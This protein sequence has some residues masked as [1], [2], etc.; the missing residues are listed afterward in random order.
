MKKILLID[1]S[2]LI[3]RAFYAI[4]NL[5]TKDNIPTGAVYGFMNM[6][7][8][9]MEKIKPDYVLVA[10]DKAGPTFRTLE[11]D[12]Y[13]ANR[14]K[15]P[16][17]LLLQFGLV[18]D[19]LDSYNVKH[20]ALD[21]YEADDIIGTVAKMANNENISVF[22]LTGDKDYFQ[23]I[24]ENSKVLFTKK[25]V[26][27]FEEYDQLKINSVYGIK[28]SEL[29]EVK[30]LM[31]DQSDNIPGVPGIGE[32][33]AL[34]LIKEYGNIE[35]IYENLDK[36]SGKSLKEKLMNNKQKA[37]MS[38]KI[39]KIFTDIKLGIDISDLTIKEPNS[40]ELYEKYKKLEFHRFMKLYS[41]QMKIDFD[42]YK[43]NEFKLIGINRIAD[44]C[45]YILNSKKLVFDILNKGDYLNTNPICIAIKGSNDHYFV[46]DLRKD[47]DIFIKKFKN[48]FEDKEILKISFDIKK[49]IILLK[50]INIDLSDNYLDLMI[51]AYLLNPS[52]EYTLKDISLSELDKDIKILEDYLGKGKNKKT[53]EDLEFEYIQEYLANNLYTIENT[54]EVFLNNLEKSEMLN[55][56]YEVDLPL[57]R[58]L[59]DMEKIGIETHRDELEK[60]GS[61]IS[62]KIELIVKEIYDLSGEEFNINS[63]KQLGDILF[64]KLDLPIIKKTKTGYSTNSEV[65][66]K[67]R[68]KHPII[69]LI[70]KYRQLS[71]INNTYVDGLLSVIGNDGRIHSKFNQ[72]I[73]ATGRLSSTEPNLQNIPIK[74]EEGKI[75]RNAFFAGKNKKLLSAD[76]S[77][78]ELRVLAAITKDKNMLNAFNQGIDIHTKTASEVF[79]IELSEVTKSQR[80]EA[81]AV[82]FGIVYGISDYGLS[83]DLKISRKKAKMYIDQYLASY[84]QISEYMKKVVKEAKENG[85]VKTLFNRIRYIPEINSS[86]FTI[87]SFGERIALNT[88]IQGTAAD[89][90]KIAM[91]NVYNR[92]KKENLKSKLILQIHDELIIEAYDEEL[93]RV[94]VILK[95]EM[96]NSVNIGVDLIVDID[97]GDNWYEI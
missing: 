93:E 9:A 10:F 83:E 69:A 73:T 95:E 34:K 94:K 2:S 88:P 1:G 16:N 49:M 21:N 5:S 56:L 33:T 68:D 91:I 92:L 64:K 59:A 23:L 57:V 18:K 15:T 38:R 71:K 41:P 50:K 70:E 78:I 13:K 79:N 96:Q 75:I 37:F 72:T 26:K 8:F 24:N 30:G 77:Q 32:K 84:P 87:R 28:P 65:L 58:V 27:D 52:R 48:L 54:Y 61:H 20:L 89:I 39:G 85:Y 60:I 74:T 14:Q 45:N 55:I 82:N 44:V 11:Y 81:K 76:Y 51:M 43:D 3:F 53:L 17:E 36:I 62:K 47:L 29:I 80:S 25:G 22:M 40:E 7:T 4:K 66:E 86:N 6:Y 63:P 90:I 31:G 46:L 19:L 12:E 35:T 97:Y 67:L 42:E